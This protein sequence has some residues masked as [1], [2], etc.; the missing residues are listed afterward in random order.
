MKEHRLMGAL[1]IVLLGLCIAGIANAATVTVTG[2]NPVAN[3]DNSVIPATGDG[4]LT[5]T[6]IEYGTCSAP[7]VF[8]TRVGE[9]SRTAGA[10]GAQFSHTLNLNPGTTCVRAFVSNTYGSESAASNVASR[11]VDP[12]TPRPPQLTTIAAQVYDVV[13]NFV[14]FRFER[15]RE[16]G[17]TKLG[18]A[19]DESRNTDT[20]FFA[21]ERPSYA[22]L[23][24]ESRSTALVARCG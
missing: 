22:K 7:N 14:H 16:V 3:T 21:L 13:P 24:R 18:M 9:V 1:A 19:C 17:T 6:R 20:D 11:T 8:G 12:P 15:G 23:T 4:S 10:P 5:T 2:T